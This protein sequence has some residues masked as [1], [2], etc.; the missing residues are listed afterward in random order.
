MSEPSGDGLS[1]WR[2][3]AEAPE[4]LALVGPGV[5]WTFAELAR[6]AAAHLGQLDAA[7]ALTGAPLFVT[8]HADPESI[9]R[10]LGLVAHGVPLVML[11]PR[12]TA[13]EVEAQVGLLTARWPGPV[14]PALLSPAPAVPDAGPDAVPPA[15]AALMPEAPLAVFF[16][17]GTTGVPKAAALPRRAFLAAAEAHTAHLGWDEDDRWLLAMPVAHVGGFSILTRCL[18][19]RRA[20]VLAPPGH[21]QAALQT[22]T[23]HAV[24]V[25]SVVPAQLARLLDAGPAPASLRAVLLGGAAAPEGLVRRARAAG[26]PVL[27]TY[28]LTEACAQVA[29]ERPDVPAPEGA[30]GPP[31]TPGA[32]RIHHGRVQVRGPQLMSGYV[33]QGRLGFDP[34]GWLETQDHGRLDEQGNLQIL[35]RDAELIVTGGENVYPLEVEAALA[36]LGAFA[37]AAVA[38]IP[39]ET[40]GEV[41]AAAVMLVPGADWAPEAW[42]AALATRLAPHKRP[43]RWI[44]LDAL[45]LTPAG[46]L[47]R[48]ALAAKLRKSLAG[49]EAAI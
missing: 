31:L 33:G 37:D 35:G 43:R 38:G 47:D 6:R 5:A 26:W 24:T 16:T 44:Q 4:R 7:G 28:G 12:L 3:A 18:Y 49:G 45:P 2:A 39:D 30:V 46:K 48:R 17:S 11:H 20:V 19:A 15:P 14:G 21:P 23:A 10:L 27:K 42:D 40:W 41:V 8:G 32:V 9:A 1:L 22:M 34:E 36:G 13:P 25:A 29:T